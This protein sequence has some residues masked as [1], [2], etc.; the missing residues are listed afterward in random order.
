M[1]LAEIYRN[2]LEKAVMG[3]ICWSR[4]KYAEIGLIRLEYPEI[5]W[6]TLGYSGTHWNT[7]EYA[8]IPWK[9]LK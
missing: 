4:Q 5:G 9:R 1:E 3:L 6:N 2:G 7:L 8:G